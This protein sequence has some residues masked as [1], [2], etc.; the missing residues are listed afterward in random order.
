VVTRVGAQTFG[1]VVD[2]VYDAEEIVV[3]PLAPILRGNAFY[4]GNTIL[5]DGSVIMILDANGISATIGHVEM[6][7]HEQTKDSASTENHADDKASFLLF[8]AGAKEL[9]AVPLELVARI[10]EIDV[11]AIEE[12]GGQHVIQ[13]RSRLMPLI[14]FNSGHIWAGEGKQPI[15]VF[16]DGDRSMGLVVDHIVDIVQ[17]RMTVEL[18][19]EHAGLI[20]GAIIAD[21]AVDVVDIGYYLTQAYADWFG[22][23]ER[24][25]TAVVAPVR[26][27]LVIDDSA[28][29]RNL[30]APLLT[31]A[32]WHVTTA[33]DGTEA[34]KLRD[35]GAAFDLII[36]DIEMPG[37]DGLTLASE[38]RRDPR[39][40]NVPMIALSA[41][42][43]EADIA[44]GEEAGFGH[45]IGKSNQADL[46][47]SLTRAVAAATMQGDRSGH[48]AVR[49]KNTA[50][51]RQE[52]RRAS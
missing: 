32:N 21:K 19:T 33:A 10:E 2:R 20:G 17:D 46:A 25:S 52:M 9:K 31:A 27:A 3:K 42:A 16:S 38:V 43:S 45:Y 47:R 39:W 1:V 37:M 41:H 34:L 48:Y 14:A 13:Y 8:Q 11:A 51:P 7:G 29:F 15:L 26:K 24:A 49:R 50:L 18:T 30:I 44:A 5:G 4:A 35:T 36:S 23:G 28:F 22:A 12:V 6:E 40:G